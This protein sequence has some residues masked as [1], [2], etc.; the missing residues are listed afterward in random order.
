MTDSLYRRIEL[1]E[2]FAADVAHELKNPVTAVRSAA[3]TL[4]YVKSEADRSE[5]LHNMQHD[6][7]R[8]NKLISDISNFSRLDAEM[9]L[10]E[11]ERVDIAKV[12]E[13]LATAF[14]DMHGRDDGSK[15]VRI[16]I[17]PSSRPLIVLGHEM[18]LGQVIT[19]LIDNAISFLPENGTVVVSCIKSGSKVEIQVED[20]GP[21]I[22]ADKLETIFGRFY[23]DRPDSERVRGKNSGLGLSISREIVEA[24]GGRIWAENVIRPDGSV[25]G[26][27][28]HV[29]LPAAGPD[30]GSSRLVRPR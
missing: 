8:L 15:P 20:N 3:E 25:D 30:T 17:P 5:L 7:N 1:S 11:A 14:N 9:T 21:G 29:R 6:L 24:H 16:Q 27:R 12:L 22:P 19:N 4:G 18:R 10:Q 28:F 26:A 13:Q 23:T 2:K